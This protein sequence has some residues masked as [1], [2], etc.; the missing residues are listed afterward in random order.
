MTSQ[1]R[2]YW[3]DTLIKISD[4]VLENFSSRTLH[5]NLEL[6]TAGPDREKYKGLEILGRL[7]AGIAP[8]LETPAMDSEEEKLR[9][10]YAGLMREAIDAATDPESPDYCMF[11][12]GTKNWNEQWLVDAAMLATGI[13]RAPKEMGE[14]LSDRVKKNLA[15]ALRKT[16]NIRAVFN[17]WLLFSAMVEAALYVLGED[18]D[19]MRVDY[20]IRQIEQWYIGD[21][22]YKDGPVFQLDYYNGFVI[23]PMYSQLVRLFHGNYTEK[24]HLYC[25]DMP[26][27]EKME[28]LVMHRLK[29]YAEIQEMSIAPDGSYP[30]FGRS[31]VYRCGAFQALA[32][33]ALWEVL[34]SSVS[35]AMA[36]CALTK[37]IK[38]TLDAEGT[39]DS[40]GFLAI[41]LCGHQPKLAQPYITTAS[42]Y[43]CT[44]AFLPLGLD[45]SKPFWSD[46]DEKT[47]WE[48]M[49]SGENM[50]GDHPMIPDDILY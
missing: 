40:N 21:G 24:H 3:V 7:A 15:K 20:A 38:K 33:A 5:R 6:E 35:P 13:V 27:G 4:P 39:F 26:V 17:N 9:L 30:P 50:S 47:T 45:E 22:F 14:K 23:Q 44:H 34:P 37:V 36:R 19:V 29:R 31:I 25:R 12:S 16:R 28:S 49:F 41:G 2:K 46:A 48:K 8:W 43:A 1:C 10:K 11:G 32:Q 18:Y 42:L